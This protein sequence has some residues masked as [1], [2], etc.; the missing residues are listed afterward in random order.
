MNASFLTNVVS[1]IRDG[2]SLVVIAYN[3]KIALLKDAAGSALR[4]R[5]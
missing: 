3:A 1:A 2:A 5:E 4:R